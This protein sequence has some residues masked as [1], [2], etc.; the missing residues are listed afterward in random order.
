MV[1]FGD[2]TKLGWVQGKDLLQVKYHFQAP[3]PPSTNN[4]NTNG[5]YVLIP[6]WRGVYAFPL[7]AFIIGDISGC[8]KGALLSVSSLSF[9]RGARKVLVYN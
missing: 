6:H 2:M 7:R 9:L 1:V 8:T 5:K 3:W 4:I